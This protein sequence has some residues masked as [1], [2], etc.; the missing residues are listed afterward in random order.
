V[1]TV[2]Y[3]PDAAKSLRRHANM[4]RRLRRALAEYAADQTVHAN[5][6]TQLVGSS[7]KRMRVG[8][9]RVVFE[10]TDDAIIVTRVGPRGSVYD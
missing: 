10:E 6:V 5:A 3:T 2:R 9:F 1:K 4:Q 8:E 7:A